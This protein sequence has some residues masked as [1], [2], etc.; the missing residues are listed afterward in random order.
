VAEKI[1][2]RQVKSGSNA[3]QNQRRTLRALG[4]K[5][6]QDEVVHVDRPSIRGMVETVSH[7]VDV[8]EIG[9]DDG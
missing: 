1:R 4:L 2:I 6:H 8:E 3:R 9:K 5:H 7:L